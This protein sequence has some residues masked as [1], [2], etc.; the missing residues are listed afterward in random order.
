[1][2]SGFFFPFIYLLAS[3]TLAEQAAHSFASSNPSIS[4][5]TLNPPMIYSPPLQ[6]ITSKEEINTSSNAIYSLINGERDREVPW[7]RLP[8]FCATEDV[9][10]AHRLCLEVQDVEKIRGKRVSLFPSN[11]PRSFIATFL[12]TEL[13]FLLVH[14][15]CD[16]KN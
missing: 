1:M 13:F 14:F 6:S 4:V 9:A 11:L 8:L 5:T 15:A 7:N 16:E 10:R 12:L 3:K 2:G